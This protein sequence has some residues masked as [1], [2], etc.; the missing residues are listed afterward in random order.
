MS[1]TTRQVDAHN[2][3]HMRACA[4]SPVQ[5]LASSHVH[6][7]ARPSYHHLHLAGRLAKVG[8]RLLLVDHCHTYV[9][10]AARSGDGDGHGACVQAA[11]PSVRGTPLACIVMIVSSV[12]A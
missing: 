9:L 6:F 5:D 10:A 8:G 1:L 3:K 7:C 2:V 11:R 4:A 12:I